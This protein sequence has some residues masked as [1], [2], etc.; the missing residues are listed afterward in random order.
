MCLS[1]DNKVLSDGIWMVCMRQPSL[2]SV[3]VCVC[4]WVE[5]MI[6]VFWDVLLWFKKKNKNFT[7]V[8]PVVLHL[9]W[10]RLAITQLLPKGPQTCGWSPPWGQR[11][12]AAPAWKLCSS[13]PVI[14]K[15]ES[16]ITTVQVKVTSTCMF[17][18]KIICINENVND[19]EKMTHYVLVT[20]VYSL[21]GF[22]T[23]PVFAQKDGNWEPV[24]WTRASGTVTA[25][26][27]QK[28]IFQD[29]I[30]K[31]KSLTR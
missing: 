27:Q 4:V 10:R 2:I 13:C 31:K 16:N 30:K 3:C 29:K 21:R 25:T 17:V 8:L 12:I 9:S 26:R 28:V 1:Y 11:D 5:G 19:S 6:S 20:V 14:I 23:S 24:S 7:C 18:V 22:C 15:S